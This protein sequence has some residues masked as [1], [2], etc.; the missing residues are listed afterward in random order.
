MALDEGHQVARV[1]LAEDHV[2]TADHRQEVR[3][4]P[5][6]DVEERHDVEDDVV[7]GEPQADLGGKA[8]Q[9]ELAMGHRH[10]LGQAVVPLV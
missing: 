5:A 7:L 2:A 8:V 1:E 9:V 4:P 6:V 10:A 3:R